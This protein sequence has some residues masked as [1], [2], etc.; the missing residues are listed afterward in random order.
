VVGV[1]NQKCPSCGGELPKE[2]GQH[3]IA[4]VSGLVNCPH[5]GAEV[6]LE[7]QSAS[8]STS[9]GSGAGAKPSSADFEAPSAAGG[10]GKP[11]AGDTFTGDDSKESFS[12]S[13]TIEGVRE[14][15]EQKPE[16]TRE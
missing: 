9:P 3:S 10:G 16:T 6:H 14:E 1:A 7:K 4:P 8:D 13:E 12:G 11:D 2:L 5:C 15:L